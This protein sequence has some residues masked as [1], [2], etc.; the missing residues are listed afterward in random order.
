M[1]DRG[2]RVRNRFLSWGF[3]FLVLLMR[4]IGYPRASRWG[5]RVGR[6]VYHLVPKNRERAFENLE[7]VFGP[8]E[9][10]VAREAMVKAV[11]E[12]FVR[13]AFELVPYGALPPEQKR[14]YVRLAGK[15]RLDRAL[16]QG[17]GVIGLSAHLG[18][19]L[20]L[21]DRLAVEGY[22]VDLIVKGSKTDGIEERL[23]ALRDELGYCSIYVT[24]RVQSV[25]ASLRSLK[26]NHVLVLHGDQRQR[27]GGIEVTFFGIPATAA[28]GPITF[29]QS[30]GAPVLPMFMI[31]N[32]DGPTHTLVIEEPLEIDPSVG[33]K[34]EVIRVHVQKYTDLIQS[35]VERYPTQWAWDHKRWVR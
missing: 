28:A 1:E 10:S 2:K 29:A 15:E 4:R 26:E 30:T 32:G 31:R 23:Q 8:G 11:F 24:P 12:N 9:P 22:P 7:R 21:T 27:D 20:I 18:N 17:R 33:S 13:S 34:Q 5:R 35:Y 3:S 19:F 14:R 16:S 6:V 25:R